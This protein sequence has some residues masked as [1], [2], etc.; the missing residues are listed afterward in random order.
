MDN[1]SLN[2]QPTKLVAARSIITALVTSG[3]L[4]LAAGVSAT[5]NMP[6]S[7]ENITEAHGIA[8][9]GEPKY[10]GSFPHFDWVYSDAPKGGKLRLMGFGTFDSLNPYTLKGTS[11]FNTPGMFMYGFSELNETLLI[12]TGSYAPSADEVQ[13]AYGLLAK[14]IR[15]PENF[16]WVEYDLRDNARF[17]DGHR[18]DASDVVFS[19]QTLTKKGHPRFQ[20]NLF[21]VQSVKK[22][23]EHSVRFTFKE[24]TGKQAIFRTG[25]MPILPEHF[26]RDKDFE[27]SSE[28]TPLLSGPY[29]IGDTK[30]GS[31]FT[32]ERVD[33]FWGRD[34]NVYQGRFNFDEVVI[35]FY[36]D[37]AV[38]FEAFKSN[39]FD[40]F[41]DYTAK[42]WAQG[43]NF[44]ALEKSDV[45]KEEIAHSI[46]SG[47][48]GFFFNTRK[49]LFQDRRVRKAIA[50]LFD[51]EWIN[52]SLFHGAYERNLSYYPNSQ[53]ASSGLPSE[54]ELTLLDPFKDSLPTEVFDTPFAFIESNGNGNIRNKLRL[55]LKLLRDAGWSLNDGKLTHI[56]SGRVFEFEFIYRQAGLERVIMPFLKNLERVGIIAKPR[57]VE[58][59][60]Y[61]AR[62]DSFDFDMMT[63]VLSQGN[64]PSYEQR[65]YYHSDV[66]SVNGSLNYAGIEN[67][68][69]DALI[70]KLLKAKSEAEVVTIMH[71]LDRVLLNEHFIVPNWHI[72]KHRLAYWNKFRRAKATLPYKLGTENWWVMEKK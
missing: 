60:Q 23:S 4:L 10:S 8:I 31:R 17:H 18:I 64:A 55:A 24:G 35:E 6:L 41:Y 57:L 33:D 47:T 40:M 69:V 59:A 45:I 61:K 30:M 1:A 44:P 43:Y 71:A 32:L 56:E 25:E 46:P 66:V 19:Y 50:E 67:R 7:T 49:D 54:D 52:S 2:P 15:Y 5:E 26:W 11:P 37:Q 68:A 21:D 72:G 22:V 28:I 51:F 63:F 65:D 13:S 29:K 58:N 48:Q 36:R 38:A 20:Q 53:Y 34:L 9:Y 12:G 42:N 3:L 39:E 14:T 62:L 70:A 27:T 16:S